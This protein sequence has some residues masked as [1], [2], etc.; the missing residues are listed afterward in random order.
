MRHGAFSARAWA[1]TRMIGTPQCEACGWPFALNDPASQ[2]CAPCAAPDRFAGSLTGKGRLDRCRSALGYDEEAAGLIMGLKYADRHDQAPALARLMAVAGDVL[3]E[4]DVTLVPVP[5]HPRRLRARRFNQA[6]LLAAGI[7]RHSGKPHTPRLLA[8][9]KPTPKQKGFSAQARRKNVAGAFRVREGQN[10]EG[11]RVVLID[12]V[13]TTGSTLIGC[14]RALRAGGAISVD[15]LTLAR[16][17]K[18]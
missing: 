4:D 2:L 11:K 3:L 8:R 5:L 18:Q 9:T 10:A 12:D 1:R 16:V 7:A 6:G 13:L 17:L 14:A 15:A